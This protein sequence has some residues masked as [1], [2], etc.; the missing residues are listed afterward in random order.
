M[1][2]YM[3]VQNLKKY[4]GIVFS[5]KIHKDPSF[6]RISKSKDYLV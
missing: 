2:K 4:G 1:Q 3:Y 5:K 6:I